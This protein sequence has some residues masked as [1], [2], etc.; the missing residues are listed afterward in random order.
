M[1]N[2]IDKNNQN[3]NFKN[4]NLMFLIRK[5]SFKSESFCIY[6]FSKR[7]KNMFIFNAI[8]YIIILNITS[9]LRIGGF[10]NAQRK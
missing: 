1:R 5:K 10:Q 8:C 4:S 9:K 7:Y 6:I 2:N 3:L